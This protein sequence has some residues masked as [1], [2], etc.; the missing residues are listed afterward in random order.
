MN[1]DDLADIFV[2]MTA[3]EKA[4]V[5]KEFRAAKKLCDYVSQDALADV[6]CWKL[7]LGDYAKPNGDDDYRECMEA[8]EAFEN[9]K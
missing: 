7:K 6:V 4:R 3:K 1:Y 2:R 9:V 8:L 5:N